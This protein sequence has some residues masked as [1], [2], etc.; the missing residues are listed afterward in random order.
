M[1][2]KY[3]LITLD[4]NAQRASAAIVTQA[5]GNVADAARAS[6]LIA[7]NFRNSRQQELAFN[8]LKVMLPEIRANQYISG[9]KLRLKN[10]VK[11]VLL[12]V[13]LQMQNGLKISV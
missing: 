8:A 5:A 7:D 12:K 3:S 4:P 10:L 6:E 11:N 9:Y 2:I 1:H 13:F